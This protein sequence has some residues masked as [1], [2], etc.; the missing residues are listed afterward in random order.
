[1]PEKH[2]TKP[3]ATNGSPKL[4]LTAFVAVYCLALGF[5]W[6]SHTPSQEEL[7]GSGGRFLHEVVHNFQSAEGLPWWSSNFMQGHSMAN[8]AMCAVPL[9]VGICGMAIFGGLVGIKIAALLIIPLS[10]LTMF[11]FVRRLTSNEWAAV[12]AAVLYVT[13][14]QMLVRIGN[15]EHWMGSYSYIFPPLILWAFLKTADEGS[16]RASAWLA[17]AW[18]AMM[19]SYAKLTFMFAPLAAVF[20]VWLLL[21]QPERRVALLRGTLVSLVLVGLMAVI[22]LLPLTR[23]YQ[24][25]SAF[26]FDNFA[27]WQQAFSIKN[28]ISVIDRANGLLAQMRP[29]FVADRG[30]F[31]LGLLTLFSVAA[32]FWWSRKHTEW[33]ATR[34]GVLLRLF[35]GMTLLALW[36]S[37]GPFSVFTGLQEF[38]KGSQKAPDWIA[39]LMWFMT[40]LPALLIYAI[41]P[42]GPR[43]GF[44]AA[45]VIVIYLF[46]PG[47]VLLEKLPMY[48][49]IRAPWGSWEVG[50]FA[51][52]VA[53]A[54]ALHQLFDALIEKRDRLVVAGL[55]GVI[56]LLDASAYFSKFF[57][58]GL[59]A[60]TFADFDRSQDYLKTSLIDGRVYPMSGRYFYLRTPMQSGRGLNSEASWSHFQ[61]RGM[62][63]LVNGANSSPGVAGISHVL[64]DKKDPFTPQEI[65][66]AFAQAYPT[67]F[68]SEYIRVLENKDSLAPAFIAREYIAMDPDTE[69]LAPAFLEAAGRA[70]AA[71]VELGANERGFPFL[72]GTGSVQNGIQLA[73]RY[74]Q[75]PG[76]PF[77]RVSY[78]QPRKNPSRMVF[79]PLGTR[80]GWLVVTEAWHPDWRAYSDGAPLPVF[81]AFG[82]LMAVP[83][84]RSEG[85]IEFVFSPPR[86]YDLCV[87]ISGLS[88]AGVLGM[89]LIMPLPFVP[90]RWKGWW[91]GAGKRTPAIKP[92]CSKIEKAVVVIPTYNERESIGK[93]LDL[94]LGLP[95]KADVLV[96]DDGSPDGTADVVRSRPEFN[97]RVF[98]LE[99][100]GKAGLGTAYRRGF[101]WAVKNSYEAA[102]EMDAD[103]S[104]DPAD[105]PKLLEALEKGAHIAVGSR[106]HGGISVLNWP[107]SR[108]F[109][110]T[111]GGLYVRTLTALPMSDPTSGFKAIRADVLR[112][113]NW[114]KVQAE[115]YAFQIEL[116]H[117]AWKQGYTI[118]EVPIVFTERREGD[119]K[120]ST[121]IS[122]EAAWRVL[123]LAAVS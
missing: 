72:A 53:G 45:L 116:H 98:L 6:L 87:W 27:G 36:L 122:L 81:K 35:V 74:A 56:L 97:K 52:A 12:L 47:F 112:D 11:L 89:L 14:G 91:T 8:F 57:A 30:Q 39:A 104:H 20:F 3:T 82:G 76:A 16:W 68:D 15:F 110:S 64:L 100:Q 92:P 62:R 23:E 107:Q 120:M 2:K 102:V 115:G 75:S 54:L 7:Y 38:L 65:Q 31:Y 111:F 63:A 113:L 32:V 79:D 42:A 59:P 19:L 46:V 67:G 61:M 49:D 51:A 28:F 48:R 96:V 106:Y 118:K 80:E 83:L 9:T 99:G 66:N 88:W 10:A 101:Q 73:Q 55:L 103:L 123:R 41:L 4:L 114:D 60:Q 108:L 94:V 78:S 26:S 25:V 37:Q 90:K 105:I 24:W 85:P 13:S 69:S 29:D 121:A 44:W 95:R 109:I 43:R 18:A 17:F 70:N 21:D 5:G 93:A 33:L 34:N 58:P 84:T 1:M 117:T 40:C 86:W 77:E 119:S 22:L 71:P 50:F